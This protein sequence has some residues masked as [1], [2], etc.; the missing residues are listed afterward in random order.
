MDA[1]QIEYELKNQ[2][3]DGPFGPVEFSAYIEDS[4]DGQVLFISH[5]KVHDEYRGNGL[6]KSTILDAINY[7]DRISKE[8]DI[9]VSKVSI[10]IGDRQ[11]SKPFLQNMGFTITREHGDQ[12]SGEAS[13]EH[14]LNCN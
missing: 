4:K 12:V 13:I 10:D 14:I 8:S 5:L 3:H 1:N 2:F 9:D 7:V 11:Q 6:G